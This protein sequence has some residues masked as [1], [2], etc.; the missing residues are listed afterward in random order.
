MHHS[1]GNKG[2]LL[3]GNLKSND[4]Q[5][6]QCGD[7]RGDSQA[8][9]D[10]RDSYGSSQTWEDSVGTHRVDGQAWEDRQSGTHNSELESIIN[11]VFCVFF[12]LFGAML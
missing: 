2:L 9:K 8:W 5:A 11:P 6:R 7:L 3:K 12:F 4:V 1:L 10:G